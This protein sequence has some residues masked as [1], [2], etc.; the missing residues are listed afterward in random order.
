MSANAAYQTSKH[1]KTAPITAGLLLLTLSAGLL[2]PLA[3]RAQTPVMAGPVLEFN[4]PAQSLNS[5]LLDFAERA[6]LELVYDFAL[7]EGRR[8]QALNGAYT[9]SEGLARLLADSGINYQF[10]SANSVSLNTTATAEKEAAAPESLPRLSV[11]GEGVARETGALRDLRL[12]DEIFDQDIST[13]YLGKEDIDRFRG[14]STADVFQGLTNVYS[15][16]ARNGGALDANIR[17]IQGAGRAPVIID[18][19]EQAIVVSRG[20]RGA[21]NR[22]YIDPSLIAG[23]QA[24]KG[25]VSV[26]EVNSQIG[27]AIAIRTLGASDI[28]RPGERFGVELRLEAG[29]NATAPRLPTLRTGQDYRQIPGFLGQDG[30]DNIFTPYRDP[31]LRVQPRTRGDNGPFA[32]GGDRAARIAAAGRKGDFDFFGAYAHRSRGNYFSGKNNADYYASDDMPA[33][34]RGVFYTRRMALK[35]QPGNEVTNSSSEM[36]SWLFKS[37]WRIADDQALQLGYRHTRTATGEIRPSRL[38]TAGRDPRN[39]NA[40]AQT[41]YDPD[42][43]YIQ[44]PLSRVRIDALNLEYKYAPETRWLDAHANLWT[45]RANSNTYSR[46]GFPNVVS[47]Y[48]DPTLINTA[49]TNARNN[50]WGMTFSNKMALLPSVDFTVGGHYQYEKLRSDDPPRP[51][52]H[53]AWISEGRAGNRQEYR[54]N[55]QLEW[56]PTSF[57]TFNGGVGHAGYRGFDDGLNARL[58]RGE[59]ESYQVRLGYK[60]GYELEVTG[61]EANEAINRVTSKKEIKDLSRQIGF[62]DNLIANPPPGFPLFILKQFRAQIQYR[63]D[64]LIKGD[65]DSAGNEPR[66]VPDSAFSLKW[67]A[68]ANGKFR[69]AGIPPRCPPQDPG[70][71]R[72]SAP[73]GAFSPADLEAAFRQIEARNKDNPE[74]NFH[75]IVAVRKALSGASCGGSTKFSGPIN[76]TLELK[77]PADNRVWRASGWEPYL[78][79]T[80]KLSDAIRLYGR[81]AE[82]LRF[83]SL[84]EST[85]G[86]GAS[87]N[88][89]RPLKPERIRAWEGAYIQD[90]SALFGFE[91]EGQRADFKLVYF[92][93]TVR[94]VIDRTNEAGVGFVN[95]DKQ[96]IDGVELQLRLDTGRF[97]LNLGATRI[98]THKLCDASR[99]ALIAFRSSVNNPPDCFKYGFGNSFL[100]ARAIPTQTFNLTLGG[101]FFE[102]RLELG[103]RAT[104]YS[105]YKN[106]QLEEFSAPGNTISGF[107]ATLPMTYG[108]TLVLDAYARYNFNDQLTAELVST[109][110][111]DQYYADPLGRSLMPAPGRQI[112]LNFMYQF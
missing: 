102:R 68:D 26:R 88:F 108:E 13:D 19:T 81:Y 60:R 103:A 27:G 110:I 74:N 77:D 106:P 86:F 37:T 85:D 1:F 112:R 92:H 65:Y 87:P 23:I 57:L 59:T 38:D 10:N 4:I 78:S 53:Y 14:I 80:L 18:G 54:A 75:R 43:G 89:L 29:N 109:N 69:R 67:L 101:R 2:N 9:A 72:R 84:F 22:S 55:M 39:P 35:Y 96:V 32:F 94:D 71:V 104:W 98:L 51:R 3:A 99:A 31:T 46:G 50:R 45:T 7:V 6:G 16:A 5:A 79:A 61:R 48:R 33:A 107:L 97:F 56:R 66:T 76:K 82:R 93:N 47:S 41:T 73:I 21:D 30:K 8:N 111:T 105:E 42:F 83:A 36:R 12:K 90:F 28:L 70:G 64:K 34:Q 58:K 44:W 25:P 17:G 40:Q 49:L 100:Q 63:L 24:L 20:Y 95:Y 62:Y 15:G 91:G 52:D 11:A